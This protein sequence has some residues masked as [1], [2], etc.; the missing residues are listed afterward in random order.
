MGPCAKAVV[1]CVILTE[2]GRRFVGRN[3]CL[4][5][6]PACPRGPGEDYTKCVEVCGQPA[7][8]EIIALNRLRAAG[9]DAR[10]AM[11]FVAHKRV[12]PS[13]AYALAAAGISWTLGTPP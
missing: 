8:A 2:D 6:Q 10:G 1:E 4:R 11:A 12:C 9:A 5:P 3:D 7:H 13:C